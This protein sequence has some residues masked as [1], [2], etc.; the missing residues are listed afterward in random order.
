MQAATI[1]YFCLFISAALCCCSI[2][3]D[4]SITCDVT[5]SYTLINNKCLCLDGNPCQP[6]PNSP[7]LQGKLYN[8]IICLVI[9]YFKGVEFYSSTQS[10]KGLLEGNNIMIYSTYP[11]PLTGVF[12]AYVY[13]DM[14]WGMLIYYKCFF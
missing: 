9:I 3:G 2:I 4:Q 7:K 11:E 6:C 1:F 10:Q 5:C 8:N 14:T 13:V 12:T